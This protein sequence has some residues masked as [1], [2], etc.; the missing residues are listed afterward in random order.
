MDKLWFSA[1]VKVW[2]SASRAKYVSHVEQAAE[3]MLNDWPEAWKKAASLRAA[4]KVALAA[5][6][7]AIKPDEAARAAFE[8]AEAKIFNYQKR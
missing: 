8:R 3:I 7:G 6:E 5:F 4:K 1:P 2:T